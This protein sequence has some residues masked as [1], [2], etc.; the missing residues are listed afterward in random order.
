[1]KKGLVL[2][3]AMLMS[4]AVCAQFGQF[5]QM[6]LLTPHYYPGE[7]YFVDGTHESYYEVE[8]PRFGHDK[9]SVKAQKEDKKR[10]VLDAAN[11]VAVKFWH[12]K[13]PD[14][15]HELY[16]VDA[17]KMVQY[18]CDLWGNPIGGN[19]WGVIYKCECYYE[20]NKKTGELEFVKFIDQYGNETPTAYLVKRT[21]MQK[22]DPIITV[23]RKK[24]K[25]YPDKKDVAE[26]FSENAEIYEGIKS[27]TLKPEDLQFIMETMAGGKA[28]E[29]PSETPA[30]PTVEAEHTTN[31][32]VG[33]DE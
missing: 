13:F 29:T 17:Q 33:D 30:E 5:K 10:T 19:S 32:E 12:P 27:G 28:D 8:L 9:I 6:S 1:M 4:M 24:A 20:I 18:Q 15:V 26:V 25:W 11:I 31:G 16:Y 7:V 22:A 23:C 3:V 2:I 14:K 21:N